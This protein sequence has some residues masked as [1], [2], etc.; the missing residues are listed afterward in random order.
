MVCRIWFGLAAAVAFCCAGSVSARPLKVLTSF[1]PVYSLTANVAG[2]LAEVENL[3]P[4]NVDPHDYQLGPRDLAKLQSADVLVI[5]GLGMED[6]LLKV[7]RS[8]RGQ[9]QPVV[10]ELADGLGTNQLIYDADAA[11]AQSSGIRSSGGKGYPN[12]HIWL[13]P[14][15]AEHG[16]TNISE[17]LQKADPGNAAG[18]ARNAAAYVGRLRALDADMKASCDKFKQR[19]LVSDHNAFAY[20]ARRYGLNV[21]GVVQ[22]VDEV[23]PSPRQL[24]R[25]E[26]TIKKDGIKVLFTSPPVPSR[27]ARLVAS[28]TGIAVA[29]LNT[30]EVGPL[31]AATYE[32]EMREN[33]KILEQYL[34]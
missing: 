34:R 1:V 12:P 19:D 28:D 21:V 24:G 11:W 22:E 3:L 23:P 33:L 31:E 7:L 20:L 8:V 9:H 25:L 27:E 15:L 26:D 30:L 2:D 10:V 32:N 5:N 17:A 13:D 16:V 14:R 6:W 4:G 29:T 18:Y